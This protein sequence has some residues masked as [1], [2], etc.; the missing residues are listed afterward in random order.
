M[1]VINTEFSES[2]HY[3]H[4]DET[5]NKFPKPETNFGYP[6]PNSASSRFFEQGDELVKGH[7]V[8]IS[9]FWVRF[10]KI[11]IIELYL[12]QISKL[13]IAESIIQK[14]L[15]TYRENVVTCQMPT[16]N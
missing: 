2:V 14:Q 3:K 8:T 13:P 12:R 1:I 11:N 5:L 10:A 15:T 6:N 7:C 9:G 16:L 4:G